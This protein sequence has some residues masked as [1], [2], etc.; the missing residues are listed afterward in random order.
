M[1]NKGMLI[2]EAFGISQAKEV[3][4]KN[5]TIPPVDDFNDPWDELSPGTQSNWERIAELLEFIIISD[6]WKQTQ[7]STEPTCLCVIRGNKRFAHAHCVVFH[8]I[9]AVGII[10][11]NGSLIYI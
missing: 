1:K 11:P 2:R 6:I 10:R 4:F 5:H 7:E 9:E 3:V 8:T